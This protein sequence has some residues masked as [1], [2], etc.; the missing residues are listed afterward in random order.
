MEA[1]AKERDKL[2][3]DQLK[4][5]RPSG[6][7]TGGPGT[8]GLSREKQERVKEAFRDS[9]GIRITLETSDAD[10]EQA[11]ANRRA[12][13]TYLANYL[14]PQEL[15]DY[16]INQDGMGPPLAV[17]L[18]DINPGEAEFIKVFLAL[19]N[20]ELN[21]PNGKLRPDLEEKLKEALGPD[22]YREYQEEQLPQNSL[23]HQLG[24]EFGLSLE[25]IQQLKDLRAKMK[26]RTTREDMV[27]YRNSV[28]AI[29]NN[30][31]AESIFFSSPTLYLLPRQVLAR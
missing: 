5:E 14:T 8:L 26:D 11:I 10:R 16:R 29:L 3:F 4:L 27:A 23:L 1:L 7:G 24:R 20:E 25:Q 15:L 28:G 9:P 2:L 13:I 6:P 31:S 18:R 21:R 22:R 17:M 19:D 12:R 30:S